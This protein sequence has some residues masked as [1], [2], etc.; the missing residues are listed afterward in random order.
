[1]KRA[2]ELEYLRWFRLNASDVMGPADSD[3]L[4]WL[5]KKFVKET[6]KLLPEGWKEVYPDDDES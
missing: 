4:D 6:K 2:T 3:C 1:M 5:N